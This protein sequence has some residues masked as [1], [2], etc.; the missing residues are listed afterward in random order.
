MLTFTF[1]V[2]STVF[3]NTL[4]TLNTYIYLY[5]NND[6]IHTIHASLY[7]HIYTII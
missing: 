6:T 5:N 1:T 2:T 3:Y 4:F 7:I